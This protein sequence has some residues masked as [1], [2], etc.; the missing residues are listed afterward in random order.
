MT[1]NGKVSEIGK[2]NRMITAQTFYRYLDDLKLELSSEMFALKADTDSRGCIL[3]NSI[4]FLFFVNK[5][6]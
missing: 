2:V 5:R 1:F 3:S 6:K 4:E